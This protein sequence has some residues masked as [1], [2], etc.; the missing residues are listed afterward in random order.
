MDLGWV[1]M[2]QVWSGLQGRLQGG[3]QGGIQGGL[4]GGFQGKRQ[5]RLQGRESRKYFK[6]SIL[7]NSCTYE[8]SGWVKASRVISRLVHLTGVT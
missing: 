2:T 4:Q 5:V 1:G 8:E 6:E 7:I 3:I